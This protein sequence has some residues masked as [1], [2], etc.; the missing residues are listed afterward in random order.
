MDR[1]KRWERVKLAYDAIAEGVAEFHADSALAALDAA[2]ARGETDEFVKPTVIASAAQIA[3]GDAVVYMNFRA[4]RARQLTQAFVDADFSGFARTRAIRLSAF[5]TLT[6]Y[7]DGLCVTAEA[8]PPQ[9]LANSLGEYLSG[10]G[11]RNCASP[12]R[13]STRTSRSSSPAAARKP[14]PARIASSCR[15]P[16]SRPTTCNRK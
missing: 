14:I 3:D 5:V 12:R 2:Y 6:H 9:S 8:Y 1:D 7:S 11:L 16:R 13:K 4:D 15:A 10:L